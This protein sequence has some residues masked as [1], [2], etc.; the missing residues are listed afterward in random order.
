[1][2]CQSFTGYAAIFDVPDRGGDVVCKGAFAKAA[3][4]GLPL[5]WQHN[6]A[7]RIGTITDI[8]ED[9]QGL[10]VIGYTTEGRALKVGTGLS[11]GYRATKWGTIND[12][13]HL[14]EIDLIEISIVNHPMQPLAVVDAV[15]N[16]P[17]PE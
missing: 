15:R 10:R 12:H 4:S 1:M 8:F 11:F 16:L 7:K 2:N 13:R 5:L 14:T 9:N 6:R 3:A 17:L